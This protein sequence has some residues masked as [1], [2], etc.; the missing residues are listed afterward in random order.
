MKSSRRNFLKKTALSATG[1]SIFF[2]TYA[3]EKKSQQPDYA[4]LDMVLAKP[5]LKTK[6][7]SSPV[8]IEKLELLRLNNNFICL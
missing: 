3:S 7:F 5:V 4:E 8:I 1:T 6:L 2:G